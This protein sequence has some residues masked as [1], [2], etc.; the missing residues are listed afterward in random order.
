L[1]AQSPS[2]TP[3]K[4]PKKKKA[5][6]DDALP[7]GPTGVNVITEMTD[8]G[9]KTY[10][11]GIGDRSGNITPHEGELSYIGELVGTGDTAKDAKA[12]F[13]GNLQHYLPRPF[14]TTV[15]SRS[16]KATPEDSTGLASAE[17]SRDQLKAALGLPSSSKMRTE[18]MIEMVG[19]QH[20]QE[21]AKA[22]P[23]VVNNSIEALLKGLD[24]TNAFVG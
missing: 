1:M 5:K 7:T 4:A 2:A 14:R 19:K 23:T 9:W 13:Y 10:S 11:P 20:A 3:A 6:R 24:I 22:Q 15:D 21:D 12:G 17:M 18:K 16:T 8:E